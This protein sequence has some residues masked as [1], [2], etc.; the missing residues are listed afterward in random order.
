MKSGWIIVWLL[1][2][3]QVPLFECIRPACHYNS[4]SPNAITRAA[5]EGE[6]GLSRR[7]EAHNQPFKI[8]LNYNFGSLYTNTE[9]LSSLFDLAVIRARLCHSWKRLSSNAWATPSPSSREASTLS[10]DG[11]PARETGMTLPQKW[12][13]RH[14][15][16]LFLLCVKQ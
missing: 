13:H 14:W 6:P 7:E 2:A 4:S 10:G 5:W 12:F 9:C 15:K 3:R 8:Q 16:K 1:S 11:H